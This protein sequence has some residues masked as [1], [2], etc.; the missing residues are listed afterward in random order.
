MTNAKFETISLQ[1]KTDQIDLYVS[2]Y[3]LTVLI[4]FIHLYY[5]NMY[6]CVVD[7]IKFKEIIYRICQII[8]YY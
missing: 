4:I 3:F 2:K 8:I 1:K 7:K 6:S 5:R